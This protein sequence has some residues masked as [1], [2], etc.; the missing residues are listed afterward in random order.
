MTLR[1]G[2]ADITI[3]AE[4][5]QTDQSSQQSFGATLNIKTYSV[6]LEAESPRLDN[7]VIAMPNTPPVSADPRVGSERFNEYAR[8]IAPD[9][10]ERVRAFWS[11][12]RQ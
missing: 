9:V 7:D 5:E 2:G 12:R 4:V 6:Q 1:R 10:V 3:T 8:R 11:A